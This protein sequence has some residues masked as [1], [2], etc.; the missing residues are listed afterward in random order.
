MQN[1]GPHNAAF[2]SA[3]SYE[4]NKC[5]YMAYISWTNMAE[6]NPKH[7]KIIWTERLEGASYAENFCG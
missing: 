4:N 3:N 1:G 6:K 7:R 5:L 2:C